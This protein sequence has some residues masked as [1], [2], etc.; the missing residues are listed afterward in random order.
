M[1]SV[2]SSTQLQLNPTIKNN[3]KKIF[4]NAINLTGA[5]AQSIAVNILPIIPLLRLNWNFIIFLDDNPIFRGLV[6][7]PNTEIIFKKHRK[8]LLNDLDR[9]IELFWEIPHLFNSKNIDIGL[10]LGDL[11]PFGLI[12]PQVVF[13]HQALLVY[14][15][16]ELAGTNGWPIIKRYFLKWFF[17]NSVQRVEMFIVQTPVMAKRLEELYRVDNKRIAII[18]QPV[19]NKFF[20]RMSKKNIQISASSKP[21]KLLFLA[22]FYLHKNHAI[23][24]KV[25]DEILRRELQD[26]IQI[27]TT[28]DSTILQKT[29]IYNIFCKYP[30]IISNL[31]TLSPEEVRGAFEASTALFLPTLVESYGLIYLEAMAAGKQILTSDLDFARWICKDIAIYFNPLDPNTIV[32]SFI[33]LRDFSHLDNKIF[34]NSY[35]NN[36]NKNWS[37]VGEEIICILD[38]ILLKGQAFKGS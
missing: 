18:S 31:G 2:L 35:L 24:T 20:E 37:Q 23:L 32:D 21:L 33:K 26:Q 29:N 25:V 1:L 9:V 15:D 30:N 16:A 6:F 12:F 10:T 8:G 14:T 11:A 3:M 34:I 28:I 5:G 4:I 38:T 36:F 19:P 7:P 17:A 13:F 22:G 27:Y